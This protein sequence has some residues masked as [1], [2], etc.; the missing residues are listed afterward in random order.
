VSD[1]LVSTTIDQQEWDAFVDSSPEASGYHLWG[2]R[3]IFNGVFGHECHYLACR[4]NGRVTGILPLV[5][6]KSYL[7]GRFGV[8]LPFV[9]YGGLV[10]NSQT[11]IDALIASATSAAASRKLAHLELRHR[12]RQCPGLEAKQHKVAMLLPLTSESELWAQFDKKARNQV[13][14]AEKNELQV[15]IGGAELLPDFYRV[16]ARNMRD[17]GTPVYSPDFFA[18]VLRQFPDST[19]VF[20]VRKEDLAIGAAI[21]YAF[22]DVIE[23]PW[24]SSLREYLSLCPNN[25]LYWSIIRYGLSNGFRTLD[26]GR[27]TPNEGT[28]HFKRQWGATPSP[29]FWEYQLLSRKTLPDQSPKNPKLRGAIEA[30]KRLPLPLANRLGPAIVRGIP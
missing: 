14:K 2:W 10:A 7:F 25:L 13:R 6:L 24:A 21:T 5:F 29:L 3:A 11:A 26:F 30:W 27:S 4:E 1:P 12:L 17:L 23:V 22:R 9:N 18:A 19:R 28:F 8:S 15:G 20:V 16:F